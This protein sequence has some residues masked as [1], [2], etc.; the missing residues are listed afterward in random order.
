MIKGYYFFYFFCDEVCK[1]LIIDGR[2]NRGQACRRG[3]TRR[4]VWGI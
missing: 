4:A 1:N 3:S 2:E